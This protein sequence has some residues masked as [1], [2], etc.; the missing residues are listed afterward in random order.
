MRVPDLRLSRPAKLTTFGRDQEPLGFVVLQQVFDD[1]APPLACVPTVA[2]E[3]DMVL[4]S[5]RQSNCSVCEGRSMRETAFH[6][7]HRGLALDSYYVVLEKVVLEKVVLE[8]VASTSNSIY[9]A[10]I[11]KS[12]PACGSL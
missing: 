12:P 3:L 8:K 1:T 11:T 5:P 7:I 9:A 4:W 6:N 2:V 10:F